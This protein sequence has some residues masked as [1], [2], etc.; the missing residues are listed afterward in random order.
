MLTYTTLFIVCMVVAVVALVLYRVVTSSRSILSSKEPV[1]MISSSPGAKK[2]HG[3]DPVPATPAYS[4][5][6]RRAAPASFAGLTPAAPTGGESVEW[7]WKD[8]RNQV[9]EQHPHHSSE[10][11]ARHC[12]LYDV[13]P[14][15]PAKKNHSWPHREDKFETGGTAY[16]VTRRVS[17]R[18]P[19]DEESGKPW[20]W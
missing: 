10:P 15:A 3:V 8:N 13:D 16:K 4:G 19:V 5:P 14:T 2:H 20:G 9:R 17:K 6:N 1:S 18:A 7:G 11:D 12:S